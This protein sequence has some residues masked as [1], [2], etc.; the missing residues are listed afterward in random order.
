MTTVKKRDDE[1]GFV[2]AGCGIFTLVF[3]VCEIF[4]SNISAIFHSWWIVPFLCLHLL[5]LAGWILV[6]KNLDNPNYDKI[7]IAVLVLGIAGILLIMGHRAAW[8]ESKSVIEDSNAAKKQTSWMQG[9]TGFFIHL[10]TDEE[11]FIFREIWLNKYA[12][13][14]T[15][16]EWSDSGRNGYYDEKRN[17]RLERRFMQFYGDKPH[18]LTKGDN[19]TIRHDGNSYKL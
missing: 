7:R 6:F 19:I 2:L 1:K 10:M 3:I 9:H 8:Q 15:I 13:T 16:Y 11:S 14:Y 12:V 5:L 17:Q 4:Y 18:K